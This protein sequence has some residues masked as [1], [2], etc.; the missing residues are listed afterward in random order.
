MQY[1]IWFKTKSIVTHAIHSSFSSHSD[2]DHDIDCT[3][4]MYGDDW[5][6]IMI[7]MTTVITRGDNERKL[8]Q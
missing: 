1:T 2:F 3:I 5:V 6:V 4:N 7:L 8:I